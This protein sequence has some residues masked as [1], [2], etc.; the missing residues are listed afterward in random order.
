MRWQ[1]LAPVGGVLLLAII[2]FL[3]W[4]FTARGWWPTVLDI[5][6]VFAALASLFLLVAFILAVIF[7]VR[8]MLAFKAEIIPVLDSLK[9]TSEAVQATASTATNFGVK[10][11]IRA[12]S[13]VV[14]ASEVASI[15]LGRGQVR[16]R[17]Q[18]RQRRRQE[19]ERELIKEE[20][21][22]RELVTEGGLDGAR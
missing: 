6:L 18:K 14:G 2:V 12:A 15:V 10:P 17:A 16:K 11:A 4:Q 1:V 20:A 3:I 19:I 21:E 9:A 8:T 7:M 13:L 22:S 5:V